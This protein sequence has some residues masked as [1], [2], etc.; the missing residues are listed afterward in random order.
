M[1]RNG[2]LSLWTEFSCRFNLLLSL[3]HT[4]HKEHLNGR[5]SR[6]VLLTCPFRWL[7]LLKNFSH[8]SHWKVLSSVCAIW[9]PLSSW[10][11]LKALWHLL[12]LK[13]RS[14][15][16]TIRCL[17]SIAVVRKPFPHW[18]QWKGVSLLCDR[19]CCFRHLAF[20]KV[21]SHWLH[22]KGRA[23]TVCVFKCSVKSPLL[24]KRFPHWLHWKGRS[25]LWITA[26]F[27]RI[28]WLLKC[29]PH[30]LHWNGLSS[31]WTTAR[32][33]L[34]LS[35]VLK[36]LQSHW[37]HLNG[38]SLLCTTLCNL[39]AAGLGNNLS[40]SSHLYFLT[41]EYLRTLQSRSSRSRSRSLLSRS[42][43]SHSCLISESSIVEKFS[44]GDEDFDVE[45]LFLVA[46]WEQLRFKSFTE[47]SFES[48]CLCSTWSMFFYMYLSWKHKGKIIDH[49]E[50]YL[51]MGQRRVLCRDKSFHK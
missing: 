13:G 48:S 12:H 40:Q 24:L 37:L 27:L 28:S 46:F 49:T 3:K 47:L 34:S 29:C 45:A 5:S 11:V 22:L 36:P 35:G 1:H 44:P 32:C 23:R 18:V 30:L 50:N 17:L 26:W 19:L 51:K 42:R 41:L 8:T 6:W 15:L 21:L 31:E 39:R 14:S 25:S 38:R 20:M 33:L 2:L 7:L 43:S 9:W 16:C 10:V 4:L